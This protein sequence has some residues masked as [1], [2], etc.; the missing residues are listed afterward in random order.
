MMPDISQ[1]LHAAIAEHQAGEVNRAADIYREILQLDPDHADASHLL[2]LTEFQQGRHQ[3]A[4]AL[5]E[6][7]IRL[8]GGVAL[9]HA[10]LGR[11]LMAAGRAEAAVAAYE[12]ARALDLDSA[13][14]QSD[15]AAAHVA[16]GNFKTA[17]EFGRRAI[18]LDP[19]MAQAHFNLGLA[20]VG[21]GL[22]LS[23]TGRFE[24]AV[25]L[26]PNF[27]DCHFEL[28]KLR[29]ETGHLDA[30][31]THYRA[32]IAGNR[33][34][35]EAHC[36]LGNVLRQVFRLDEAAA[37]Y[38]CALEIDPGIAEIYA[39]LGVTL[40]EMG[41]LNQAMDAYDRA[42]AI[43]PDDAEAR[44]NRAMALLQL[45]RFEDGWR[46]FEWRWRTR[47]F[48]AIRRAWEKPQWLGERLDG[49]TVLVHAEQGYGDCVQFARYLPMIAAAGGRVVVECPDVLSG[50]IRA[51]A[52]VAD[53]VAVGA[54]LP[55]HDFQIPMMSLPGVSKTDF[56]TMPSAT[57]Y[58]AAPTAVIETW[59]EKMALVDGFKVG[60]AWSGSA[61]HQRNAWRSPGLKALLPLVG[62]E[63]IRFYSLQVD[64]GGDELIA[65]GVDGKVVDLAPALTDFTETAAVM[66]NLDLIIAPDT[67]VAHLAGAL[68]RPVW[69]MLPF[70]SEWRWFTERADSPWY[71]TMRL[72][73]QPSR[74]DWPGVVETMIE[75]IGEIK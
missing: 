66:I 40:Q 58:L 39:N 72:F 21:S 70:A 34:M 53:V 51:V 29:Q 62:L 30:A 71:P 16:V 68:A 64:N 46:D 37:S 33:L 18:G 49:A 52:G 69:L 6:T 47:H 11:T 55:A 15:L 22:T 5:I 59:R 48:S 7:A 24:T 41:L 36:N 57:P 75:A 8:N 74:G 19:G 12:N 50:L 27:P 67:A 32:A 73:R 63:R 38:R 43:A 54:P 4:A 14:I 26:A 9:Y 35:V 23:A 13:E 1:K 17:I 61:N 31:I 10:N 25:R 28:A 20:E 3:A 44:R 65:E 56:E 2:G 42:V 60:I 45:G